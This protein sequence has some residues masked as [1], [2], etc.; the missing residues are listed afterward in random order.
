MRILLLPALV[1]LAAPALSATE[2]KR[3]VLVL[4]FDNT[5]KNKNH[6]W[7]SDSIADN[8]K[9]DLLKSGRFEVLDVTLLRKID[10]K[11]QFANLDARNASAFAARLNCEVAVVGR[12]S[13]RKEGKKEIVSFE[14]DGVDAL[15]KQS[16]VVRKEDAQINA[17]IFDTVDHLA[18]S[19]SDEL[20]A[21]LKP[22][23]AESFRRDNKLEKLIQ[24]LE[25]PPKG[26]LDEL[27]IAGLKL[28]P[29]FDIDTFEYEVPMTYDD[30]KEFPKIRYEY[31]Y[32]G[33]R[34]TPHLATEKLECKGDE[35]AITGHEPVM[36]IAASKNPDAITYTVRFKTPDPRGPIVARWWVATGYPYLKSFNVLGQSNPSAIEPGSKLQLDAMRGFGFFEAGLTPGRWQFLPWQMRWAVTMQAGYGQGEM[37]Q[38]LADNPTKAKIHLLTLGGGVR[39]D[40]IFQFGRVYALAPFIAYTTH[41]QRYFRQIDT[42]F[43]QTVGFV[44]ELGVNNYFRLGRRSPW[45]LMVTLAAGSYIYSGENL[46]YFRGAIGVEYVIK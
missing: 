42:G 30:L 8:L 39:F 14:A 28:T 36:K 12:F 31:Q 7:M 4:P 26:F 40:R 10:P 33:D 23:D 13:A 35:C 25:N 19:I 22:L 16:V 3:R 5:L 9:T 32:W 2:L 18:L 38:Y 43:L 20:V 15:E 21:K 11:M 45:H 44:P 6:A 24:R 37:A 34:K 29:A 17:E 1:L 27:H 41:Y 46:T